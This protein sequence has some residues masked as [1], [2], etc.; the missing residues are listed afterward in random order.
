MEE[1]KE[2]F[3]ASQQKPMPHSTNR[4]SVL[5]TST[6]EST[7]DMLTPQS[8]VTT[9][10]RTEQAVPDR[11]PYPSSDQT[12]VFVCS[13]TLCRGTEIPLQVHMVDSNAPLTI[14]ALV[15]SG[16]IGQFIDVRCLV[17]EL[18]SSASTQGHPS[19]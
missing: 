3:Q 10:L 13:P 4:F 18:T 9:E 19:L 16:A 11:T 12:P 15:D 8:S 17:K 7:R 6:V 5:K 2:N 1:A 14:T